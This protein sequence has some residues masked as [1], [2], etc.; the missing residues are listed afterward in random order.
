M[1][2]QETKQMF[3]RF[4]SI[5]WFKKNAWQD[6][7]DDWWPSQE[8]YELWDKDSTD[9]LSK[10]IMGRDVGEVVSYYDYISNNPQWG[11]DEVITEEKYPE[12]F[13]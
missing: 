7:D 2:H 4:R 8:H 12:Y 1:K 6:F 5:D 13:L 9:E 3:I 10:W 11:I